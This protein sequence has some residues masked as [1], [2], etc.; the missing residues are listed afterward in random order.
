MNYRVAVRALCEFTAKAGDLDLRFTPSPTA[1]EGMEGHRRVVARRAAGYE[2]EVALEGAYQGLQ[3]RGRA[4]GYDPAAN[5]LEEIKTYRGDLAR[6]PANHRQLHWAQAKVYAWLLC[7]ARQLPAIEVALVYLNVDNDGQTLISEHYRAAE[8][9][10]FFETQCQCFLAWAQAQTQRLAERDR[11]LQSLGFPYPQF[12]QG[13]RQLAETLYKAVSTGRCLMAQASTGIGKTLGTLFPL[14]KAMVPQ[15]LDKVFF[16]TAK[17]PGRALALDALQQI[18]Q[19]TPQ[20]ALRTL[21]LI[22]RDKACENPDKACHGEACPL[23]RG[24]YD[25]LPAAREAAARLPLLD[26]ANLREVALEHQVCPYYLG[27]EM[28]RWVDVL[29]A[30][31]NYYFDAHALL[32]GLTQANQWRVA[33]LVDEAHNLV[34][35]GRGMYSASLDQGQLL[36]LRQRKPPGLASAL[37]RLNRQWNA[38]YKAQRAP[39]LATEQLPD[40]FMRSLQQCIGLIQE[41]L[42]ESPVDVDAHILQFYFQALQFSRVAELFDEHFLFDVSLRAGPRQRRL[43]TLCLRNVTPAKLLGPRMQVARSVTLF[44]ATLSP[45]HFYTDLLGMPADTAWLEVAAPFRAEQLEVRIASQVSTRYHERQASLAPIVALI[46][47]QY[48]R[49][50]GNY[51]AFFSSFEYL[52]QVH[53]LLAERHP[54][55]SAWAQAPG[56]DEAAR[57]DFLARFAADGQGVGFAVLG[58]A[59]GEGVDLPGSRLIGAFV[60]TLGLPQVNPVNEQFKQRLGR[61]FGAGFDYVYLYPGVRKVIQAAGRVIRGDQDRGVLVLIDQRFVE[62]RVQQMFPGWWQITRE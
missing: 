3:V 52:Q 7:Q 15:Q 31:Y 29:V 14:L 40:A 21:E 34:E 55:I 42:N 39:Y 24:F 22:A 50:P 60:A 43:A 48:Q 10:A 18:T 56:M 61:Q 6:Q 51:L 4:D 11:G 35:R 26:R 33:V 54:A 23:A 20:P 58:G 5:R 44:S 38:V 8:L 28:A 37:D 16:L 12:R 59:F 49:Q 17:T 13:Q 19:A 45:R 32:F 62:P 46:A 30:D 25:R 27:Q 1:Q 2:A 9:H 53:A 47:E 57:Q 41:R 36:A